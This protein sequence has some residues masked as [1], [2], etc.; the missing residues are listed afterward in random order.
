MINMIN[1]MY[2]PMI[3]IFGQYYVNN[4]ATREIHIKKKFIESRLFYIIDYFNN[5]TTILQ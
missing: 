5:I 1:G 2:W 4:C 3:D